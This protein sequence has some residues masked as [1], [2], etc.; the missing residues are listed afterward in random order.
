MR[1]WICWSQWTWK[2][3]LLN[4][5]KKNL[6]EYN[7]INEVAREVIKE[8]WRPQDMKANDRLVFQ[9]IIMMKQIIEENKN[10]H[11]ISD[12]TIYDIMAYSEWLTWNLF[13]KIKKLFDENKNNYDIIFYVP[14]E[15]EMEQDWIRFENETYRKQIDKKILKLL[16]KNNIKYIILQWSI[17]ERVKQALKSIDTSI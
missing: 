16:N 2:S 9:Y 4:E 3:T 12:R 5:L 15:F 1:I 17:Q 11:F 13:D 8:L 14:I 10:N 6:I 7:Y